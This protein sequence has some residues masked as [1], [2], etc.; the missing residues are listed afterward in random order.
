MVIK[1]KV[2]MTQSTIFTIEVVAALTMLVGVSGI[3]WNRIKTSK[4]IG[5]RVIQLSFVFMA[6][7][8]VLI[9]GLEGKLDSS[10]TAALMGSA[11]GYLFS[12]ISNFDKSES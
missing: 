11:V 12:N 1:L 5:V 4:G 7:P 3:M 9:L 10:A 8:S 6:V 2:K